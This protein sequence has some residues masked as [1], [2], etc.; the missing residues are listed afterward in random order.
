ME[1]RDHSESGRKELKFVYS[2]LKSLTIFL[3]ALSR[4]LAAWPMAFRRGICVVILWRTS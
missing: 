2:M 1:D 4:E 3:C